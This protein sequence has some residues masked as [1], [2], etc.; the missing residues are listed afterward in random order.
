M[1]DHQSEEQAS[2]LLCNL[3]SQGMT[4][5][6]ARAE[7]ARRDAAAEKPKAPEVPGVDLENVDSVKAALTAAKVDFHANAK[8]PT[9]VKLLKKHAAEAAAAEKLEKEADEEPGAE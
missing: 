7:I 9:L 4:L 3:V 1:S 2:L 5:K 8:L 6:Q